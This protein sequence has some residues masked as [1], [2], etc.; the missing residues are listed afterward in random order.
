MG[1]HWLVG[2]VER[3]GHQCPPP[4]DGA[5]VTEVWRTVASSSGLSTDALVR[6]VARHFRLDVADLTASQS[7][8]AKLV[9]EKVARQFLVFPVREDDRRLVVATADPMDVEAEQMLGFASGRTPTFVVAPP[10]AIES[11]INAEYAPDRS[12]ESILLT[13]DADA[14]DGVTIIEEGGGA[15]VGVGEAESAPVVRLTNALF[16]E[17]VSHRASDIHLEPGRSGG[18]IRFRVDGVMQP[19]MH[20]PMPAL[21]R[22]ISRIK[23]LSKLDIADRM[24]PQDGRTRIRVREKVY[25]LRISTVPTRDAEKVVIRVLDPQGAV[26]LAD[27]GLPKPEEA[28]LRRLLSNRDGIVLITGPTGSGKTTTLYAAVKELSA[29]PINIMTVED[30]VE[31]ELKGI[32]QIQV[33]RKRDVTF[34]SALRAALRQDP[35]VIM[36]GEIRDLETAEIAVRASITGHL[37]LGTL[38]AND[39]LASVARLRDL[40]MDAA[41]LADALRG[42]L[43]QRLVRRICRACAVRVRDDPLNERESQ[44]AALYGVRQE[45]R[46]RGCEACGTTGYRGRLPILEVAVLT[47]EIGEMIRQGAGARELA[48]AARVAGMRP[49]RDVAAEMV[50]AGLTT[51]EEIDRV[52]G[53]SAQTVTTESASEPERAPTVL[54]VDDDSLVRIVARQLMERQGFQVIEAADGATALRALLEDERVDL[55]VLDLGMPEMDGRAVLRAVRAAPRTAG[56]PVVVLTGEQQ[57]DV[58]V[59][60]MNEG[61]DDY[62]RKPIEPAR[63]VAR[64]KAALRRAGS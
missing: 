13:V 4:P 62:I 51:L 54:L 2:V 21:I 41:L 17:A 36:V 52:L 42:A 22:V 9:P 28:A 12:V 59:E 18:V 49:M 44:L 55:V 24:R 60:L 33:E 57:D 26:T 56:L 50:R 7:A 30:P 3:A 27:A 58:E 39:A 46:A 63:F 34:A 20:L 14:A 40:G 61:A 31:Y 6:L 16:Q 11:A 38:H 64:I 15:E 1:A 47:A 25:D 29:H 8:A 43:A 10:E 45:V 53:E 37:V 35:D 19:F 23:I 48:D 5:G 32:T